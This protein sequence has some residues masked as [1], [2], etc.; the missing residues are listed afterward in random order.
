MPAGFSI[1]ESLL[2]AD[3]RERAR[4]FRRATDRESFVIARGL[5]R[6]LLGCYL[7]SRPGTLRFQYSA[8]GKPELCDEHRRNGLQFN[9]SHS[10]E[11]IAIAFALKRRVGVDVEQVQDD[12]FHESVA[13][14]FFSTAES[15]TLLALPHS[16]RLQAFYKCWTRKEAYLKAVGSGIS[17]A[18][19]GLDDISFEGGRTS[20]FVQNR[21]EKGGME[22]WQVRDLDLQPGYAA[23]LATECLP[24]IAAE[25]C[26]SG[27]ASSLEPQFSY[28]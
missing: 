21:T 9:L 14:K 1:F 13:E 19:D 24:A 7:G 2:S 16:E 26:M 23:A 18:L 12:S 15:A 17:S 8:N 27:P 6:I 3:E 11:V 10:G 5:L 4:R 22:C 25:S 20:G 28:A